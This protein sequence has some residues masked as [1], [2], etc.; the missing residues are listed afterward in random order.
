MILCQA[1]ETA[2]RNM[3]RIV[4]SKS[5]PVFNLRLTVLALKKRKVLMAMTFAPCTWVL[6]LPTHYALS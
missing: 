6:K 3:I 1:Q 4:M 5:V 2:I